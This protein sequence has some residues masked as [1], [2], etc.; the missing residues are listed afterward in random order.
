[1]SLSRDGRTLAA[2]IG[3]EIHVL[4]WSDGTIRHRLRAQPSLRRSSVSPDGRLIAAWCQDNREA[5][6]WDSLT[7]EVAHR[8]TVPGLGAEL[9]EFSPDGR[10]LV[11]TTPEEYAGFETGTWRRMWAIRRAGTFGAGVAFSPDGRLLA[12][13]HSTTLVK[14][15]RAGTAEE[16]A[17]LPSPDPHI[18]RRLRFT[19]D[20]TRLVASTESDRLFVWDL[21]VIRAR[22]ARLGLDWNLPPY[23]PAGG[24]PPP[25]RV[26]ADLGELHPARRQAAD[27]RRALRDRPDDAG[28]C[29]KLAWQ[30]V[31]GPADLRDPCAG[32]PLAERATRLDPRHHLLTTL[33]VVYYRL[34]R[35]R[36]AV[37]VLNRSIAAAKEATAFNRFFL[38]LCHH[39]LGDPQRARAEYARAVAWM[40]LYRP[41][42][43]ELVRFRTEVESVLGR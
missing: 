41:D 9:F 15:Y 17:A 24:S 2:N 33:G 13:G 40:E 26:E 37:E 38:A 16:V 28:A 42:D 30:L 3:R 19:P 25:V 43:E 7:G 1:V 36:D 34:D 21:R 31:T 11:A 29:N 4:D 27:L 35:W 22:L 23:P 8:L 10:W 6:V 14:L 32:L 20:G 18:L 5:R 12:V 39:Q